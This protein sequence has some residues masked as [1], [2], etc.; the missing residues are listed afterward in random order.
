MENTADPFAISPGTTIHKWRIV[1]ELGRGTYG[2]VYKVADDELHR[3]AAMKVERRAISPEYRMLK[4]EVAVMIELR[5]K[6]VKNCV[7]LFDHGCTPI[8]NYMVMSLVGHNLESLADKIA[9][10]NN[11]KESKFTLYTAFYIGIST[12]DTLYDLHKCLFLHRDVKPA[13]FAIGCHAADLTTIYLLDFGTTR[14]YAKENGLHHRPRAKVAFRGST[15]YASAN[16]LRERDQSRR[17]DIWSWLFTL[18]SLTVGKLPW[19]KLKMP[20]QCT[21]IQQQERYA[22]AK[23]MCTKR[24][25]LLLKGC[26]PEYE[27]VMSYMT[28]LL[29]YSRPNYEA[30]RSALQKGIDRLKAGGETPQLEW[31]T[32]MR[33]IPKSQSSTSLYSLASTVVPPPTL[34]PPSAPPPSAPPPPLPPVSPKQEAK[35][36]GVMSLWKVIK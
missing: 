17:D 33:K 27:E 16:A 29:F 19:S 23:V 5:A 21:F 4:V 18:I 3:D 6:K 26:P 32:A 11:K 24:P 31:E 28:E 36:V 8:F 22:T 15:L 25:E 1:K 30:I 10:L 14:R 2:A 13:N 9:K 34:V 12:L 7:Q 20:K 35:Q